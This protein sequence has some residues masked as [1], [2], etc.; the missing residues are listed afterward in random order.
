MHHQPRKYTQIRHETKTWGK[1]YNSYGNLYYYICGL[2]NIN[3]HSCDTAELELQSGRLPRD[4]AKHKHTWT[5]EKIKA[6]R[7]KQADF[8]SARKK[9][10][11][12]HPQLAGPR[13]SLYII[14]VH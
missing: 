9:N 11:W 2:I 13:S 7:K 10:T 5:Q 4:T 3:T 8:S 14:A 1:T 12:F 6:E